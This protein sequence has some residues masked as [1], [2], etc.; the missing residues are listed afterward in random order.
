NG[1]AENSRMARTSS[2]SGTHA[3][4]NCAA[5]PGLIQERDVLFPRQADHDVQAEFVRLIQNPRGR[6]TISPDSVDS[7]CGHAFEVSR[8]LARV[9][10]FASILARSE[11]PVRNPSHVE[12]L[13]AEK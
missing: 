7:V 4:G 3:I 6:Y 8:H 1:V 9:R 5:P 13:I 11:R 12:F 10:I 2:H